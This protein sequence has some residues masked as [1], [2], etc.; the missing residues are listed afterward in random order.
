MYHLPRTTPESVGISSRA[1]LELMQKLG[2]LE[3]INSIMIMRHGQVCLETWVEPYKKDVPHQ[4]FS[5][6][7]SFVSCAV[8]LA[9]KA[10]LLKIS[11]KL[12]A[13]FP[14]Y[15]NAVTDPMM[16]QVTLQDLL[17]MRSGHLQCATR[18]FWER[19]D[20]CKAF[21]ESKLDT[22][23]GT[24]FTYNSAATYML[25]AVI[26]KV[27]GLNVREY[28]MDKLFQ[29][30]GIA[31]GLWENS[32][33]NINCG[34]WGL[35]LCTEDIAKFS[36]MLLQNGF[37]Q[38]REVVPREYIAEA[39]Q[40]HA[41]NST[42]T[43]IDWQQGY[44][45][46]FWRSLHGFRG[47]G[48]SGQYAVMLPEQDIAI[49]VTSCVGNMHEILTAFW[50]ILLPAAGDKSLPE[51]SA[52]VNELHAY[53]NNMAIPAVPGDITRRGENRTFYFAENPEKIKS[54]EVTFGEKECTLTFNGPHGIEQ[55]RAGFGFF[56]QSIFQL[57][58][59]CAHLV[60]ASAAWTGDHT[61][62]IHT[63]ITD[64]IYRD[65]WVVDF[66]DPAEPL[67]NQS[68]CSC[69]RPLKPRFTALNAE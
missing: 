4:L 51:E 49:A 31:P 30:L 35:Y 23:P 36:Q 68:L 28:L 26:R 65:I 34:G 37:W 8:G 11:D 24:T 6:S 54:C 66:N 52:A 9:Q 15:A 7:K 48:A 29:P 27:T 41:D 45:Y 22:T 3:Y 58:D 2:K 39:V 13:F 33:E 57:T 10:N 5:L 47:D 38:G 16:N 14:E 1:L 25:A 40:K 64:G 61:L 53:I 46:Q 62:A 21:L 59:H 50:E 17:T 32:P 55:L 67:K 63:F 18:F 12:V 42:N 44:G 43:L 20:W 60:A 69:F 19:R 56:A